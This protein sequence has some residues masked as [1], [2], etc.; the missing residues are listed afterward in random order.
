MK[1]LL[2]VNATAGRRKAAQ[3]INGLIVALKDH[4]H[5]VTLAETHSEE[6]AEAAL[7]KAGA[8]HELVVCRGG[9]GTLNTTIGLLFKLGLPPVLGYVPAGSTNDFAGSLKLPKLPA[10]AAESL[11]VG[12]PNPLDLGRFQDRH[13]VYVASFGA[14]TQTSYNTT[15]SL[16]NALGH[17]AYL[18]T[19]MQE[20][21]RLKAYRVQVETEEGLHE[22]NYIFGAVSNTTSIGGVITL[23][24]ENVAFDDG[25]LEVTLVKMPENVIELSRII[26]CLMSGH[27][28]EALISFLHTK[29][30]VFRCE[31][32]MPW[33]LDGDYAEG[34]K[35]VDIRCEPGAYSLVY[36][37]TELVEQ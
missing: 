15:Q 35:E 1:I 25:K 32:P 10:A 33:S 21:P 24:R 13:F 7:A 37:R 2:L 30:A 12:M 3:E 23:N 26:F 20:L 11:T 17:L 6:E 22:G 29:R 14:F 27:Y 8:E 9:D 31:E 5:K 28:D 16:K 19:G 18:V 36:E 34:G 4:G